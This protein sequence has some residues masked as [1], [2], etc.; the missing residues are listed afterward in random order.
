MIICC[1]FVCFILFFWIFYFGDYRYDISFVN[2]SGTKIYVE[3]KS[4]I[5]KKEF[6]TNMPINYREISLIEEMNSQTEQ[7]YL[8]TRVFNVNSERPEI[9]V[10]KGYLA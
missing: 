4:T 7:N 9:F 2:N 8:I 6:Q 10:F 1:F 3:V 5:T